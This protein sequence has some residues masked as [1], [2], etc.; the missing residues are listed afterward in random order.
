MG[1]SYLS[2]MYITLCI[3]IISFI[4]HCVIVTAQWNE[5]TGLYMLTLVSHIK[6]F[7]LRIHSVFLEVHGLMID[8]IR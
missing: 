2:Y 1:K 7:C 6:L 3:Q 5:W 4:K 8:T